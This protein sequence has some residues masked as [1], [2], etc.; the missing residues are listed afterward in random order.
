MALLETGVHWT[1]IVG[2]IAGGLV[3]VDALVQWFSSKVVL[4]VFERELPLKVDPAV[5]DPTAEAV[6]IP[7][8]GGLNLQG[9]LYRPTAGEPRGLIVFC[10]ELHGRHFS[11][12]AYCGG[13][14]DAGFAVLS[15]EF[16]N[17][18]ESDF[19]PG[20]EPLHWVTEYELQDALAALAYT[21]T[22]DDLNQL[23]LGMMGVS[24]GGGTALAAAATTP[25]VGWVAVEGAFSTSALLMH[26]TLRWASLYVPE[27][28][29]RILP[30][31]HLR[32]TLAL[33][34]WRSGWRRG[35][36]YPAIE[37]L[38]P[39]LRNRDVLMISGKSDSYVP[40]DIAER[41]AAR[42]G[43]TR[44]EV[45]AVRKGRHNGARRVDPEAYDTRLVEFFTRMDRA[46]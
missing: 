2:M 20:Y 12:M 9:S 14:R 30:M 26:Y 41:M 5:E 4:Q 25:E 13:L 17:Q 18:G 16:R 45:W 15:F 37:R 11:A 21:K 29:L 39:R 40:T 35:C 6:T 8:S 28:Y 34:R 10:P 38:L 42:I 44:C 31:W 19:V 46:H 24:R 1:V 32:L 7:T 33:T 43:G 22:R 23:P 27:W 36:R 3:A